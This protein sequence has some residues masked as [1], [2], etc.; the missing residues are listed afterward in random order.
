M[1]L[2][3]I[4]GAGSNSI[5]WHYQAEYFP[6]SILVNL[7]GH[8]DD[9]PCISLDEYAVWLNQYL[10]SAGCNDIVL[11][12]HSMGGA[13]AL[14]YTLKYP[15]IPI[16]LVLIGTLG[17][18]RSNPRFLKMIE[19]GINNPSSWIDKF[20]T[21]H[22]KKVAPWLRERVITEI[23]RSGARVQLNDF[24]CCDNFNVLDKV[25]TV[26]VP[27]LIICGSEDTM[28]PVK[29]SRYLADQINRAKF[30]V[31]D[32]GTHVVFM[33]KPDEVNKAVTEFLHTISKVKTDT[34]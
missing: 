23:A 24:L 15:D 19:A 12:G 6:D 34:S 13:L 25:H 4:P 21:P 8:P 29:Y 7:P 28:T 22:Y 20:V 27:T 17:K 9:N 30:V 1:K 10:V 18:S 33:E 26:K 2:V 11:V 31:I 32:G 14:T 3:F 16:G 5:V